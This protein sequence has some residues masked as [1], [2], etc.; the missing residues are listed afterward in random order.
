MDKNIK[1]DKETISNMK[2][3]K[4][5]FGDKSNANGKGFEYK[6]GEINET[7]NWNPE[8]EDP[9]EMGGFNFSIKSKII[10]WLVRGDTLYDVIIPEDAE[11]IDCKHPS[12]PHGVFRSNKIILENPR[13]VTDEMAMEFYLESDIPEKS[14][15]KAMA[16]CAIRGYLKTM[17][18]I[19]DDKINK[20]TID[21]AI[22]EINDFYMPEGANG[23]NS[24]R[25]IKMLNDYKDANK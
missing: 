12:T 13:K 6:I 3:I 14:Y 15:Y 17:K 1:L 19:F 21:L 25:L 8:S 7:D 18:K 20:D 23:E 11:V 4:V 9:K 16:G 5:M 10:R 22:E 2:F 24:R